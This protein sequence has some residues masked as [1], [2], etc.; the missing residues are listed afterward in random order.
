MIWKTIIFWVA[1]LLLADAG[2]GLLFLTAWQKRLP[3]LNIQKIA[4]V[5][6]LISSILLAVY[7]FA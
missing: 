6:V 2:M 3:S 4:T 5:E 1:V 7:F